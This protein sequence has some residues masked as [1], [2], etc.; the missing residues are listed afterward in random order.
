MNRYEEYESM[1]AEPHKPAEVDFEDMHELPA[2][3][4]C[5]PT[6]EGPTVTFDEKCPKCGGSGSWRGG[7]MSSLG[8]SRCTKCK[9]SGKLTFKTSPEF[10][11]KSKAAR[12]RAKVRK[13]EADGVAAL[14]RWGAWLKEHEAIADWLTAANERGFN[15]ATSLA[16]SGLKFGSL[17]ENQCA[18][19]YKCIARDEDHAEAQ[20]NPAATVNLDSLLGA[21][22]NAFDSGLK[23]PKL[24]IGRL[25][26]SR[27]GDK[28]A[29]PG[30]LY[31]K[32]EG[33]YVG[34]ID[35]DGGF[36]KAYKC[37][38]ADVQDIAELGDD[39]LAKAVEHG[40]RTG[41]CACCNRKLTAA[42]S[43]ERG[44]GPICAERWGLL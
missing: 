42:E 26:F 33:D 19:A 38:D 15:F 16:T 35:P 20:K 37:T 29:N 39:V 34:K 1:T 24:H 4:V 7:R 14:K 22:G 13:A 11:A 6:P 5:R 41:N 10:R 18:A 23:R 9:G 31:V 30:Y 44:I 32:A 21:C 36:L 17:T 27:A 40:R 8:H 12:Q 25:Q 43:V 2:E 3:G 28:S